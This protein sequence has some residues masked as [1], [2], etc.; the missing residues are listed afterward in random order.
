MKQLIRK[1]CG[2]SGHPGVIVLNLVVMELK[3]EIGNAK[4]R[5]IKPHASVNIRKPSNVAPN[6]VF[7]GLVAPRYLSTLWAQRLMLRLF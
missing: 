5:K 3:L 2:L 4:H 7:K 1:M 6:R